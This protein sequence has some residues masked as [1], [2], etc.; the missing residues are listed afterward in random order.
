MLTCPYHAWSYGLDGE[1]RSTPYFGGTDPRSR[2]EGFDPKHHGLKPV[3]CAVWYDWIFV[4]VSGDAP[5][6]EAFI[7]PVQERLG[8]IDFSQAKLVGVVDLGVVHANWK[9]LVENFIEPYHVQFVH[10]KTTEQPLANHYTII[11]RNCLGSAVDLEESREGGDGSGRTLAV[12][13]RY[14]SL[15]PTFVIGRYF[16]NQIGV[17]LNVPLGPAKTLQRRAIYVTDAIEPTEEAAESLKRL[18]IDVHREDHE[19]CV[20]LQEGRKSEVAQDGGLLSPHW[21]SS[22]RKFQELV[23]DAI[24]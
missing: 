17:H 7:S 21:E 19:I 15:F 23:A 14:L 22:V 1:L 10:A 5:P 4:N 11:D 24:D 2:P 18:W 12:S 13:S 20:R 3:R 16:P 8:D 9:F 6:F